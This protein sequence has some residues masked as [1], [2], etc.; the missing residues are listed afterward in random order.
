MT[1]TQRDLQACHIG[2]NVIPKYL[3][4]TP[5]S[6]P[7][8]IFKQ[9]AQINLQYSYTVTF[10]LNSFIHF[11]FIIVHL[12][13]LLTPYYIYTHLH[14]FYRSFKNSSIKNNRKVYIRDDLVMKPLILLCT[15][16]H[17]LSKELSLLNRLNVLFIYN[18]SL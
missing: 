14:R 18:L 7:G 2:C 5:Y 8:C 13:I 4:N 15:V 11:V 17:Y 16:S 1:N 12:F 6:Q 9:V 10:R 3:Q